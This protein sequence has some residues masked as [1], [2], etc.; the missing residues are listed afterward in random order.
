MNRSRALLVVLLVVTAAMAG[1]LVAEERPGQ[2]PAAPPGSAG[3]ATAAG[4]AEAMAK[5]HFLL[6]RWEGEG[7]MRMG[8]GEPQT[9]Q[10]TE[11]VAAKLDGRVVLIEGLGTVPDAAGG[12][13]RVVHQAF[14]MLSYDAGAG[15]Y[16]LRAVRGDGQ[17]VDADV[18]VGDHRIVWSFATPM[19]QVRYTITLDEESR[20]RELGEHSRDGASW[21]QFFEM[22]LRRV[23]DA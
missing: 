18:E 20:W 9:S 22:T 5:V 21:A 19:G 16:L 4:T 17:T 15:R 14:G 13:P 6:G 3:P 2:P 23:G 10:V 11:R 12:A 8:P 1:A 7:T